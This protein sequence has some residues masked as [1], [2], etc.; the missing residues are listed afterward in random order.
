MKLALVQ[1]SPA[2]ENPEENIHK[3]NS[4]LEQQLGEEEIIIFPEMTLTGF[5]MQSRKFAEDWDGI[6]TKYFI[7]IAKKHKKHVF[8]GIIEREDNKIYNSLYHID[9]NG[10]ITARYRKIHPFSYSKED[11]FYSAG[12]E[13]ITT[14]IN[15]TKIGLTICYDLRFPELYRKYAKDGAE[16]IINIAD[17]PV[18]R[19]EHY[20]VLLRANAITNQ[21]YMIGVNRVGDDPYYSYPGWSAVFNPM[22]EKVILVS[23]EEKLISVDISL[24]KVKQT[25]DKLPFL[26]DIKL[27]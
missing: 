5:T 25:R 18:Q 12:K 16:I 4:M 11:E 13:I 21:C 22:G 7:N 14:K 10:I 3:L 2:W 9:N 8:A 26:K 24:D 23:K 15:Q 27:I 19:I 1:Y 17:W 20:K 6:A